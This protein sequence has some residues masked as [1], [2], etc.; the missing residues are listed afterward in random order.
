MHIHTYIPAADTNE[1][2]RMVGDGMGAPFCREVADFWQLDPV[3]AR[4]GS[5]VF[6]AFFWPRHPRILLHVVQTF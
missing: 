3:C 6:V 5:S 2:I 4:R 1:I